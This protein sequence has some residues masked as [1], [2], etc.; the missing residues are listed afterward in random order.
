MSVA[1]PTRANVVS[2]FGRIT[3]VVREAAQKEDRRWEKIRLRPPNTNSTGA[4]VR[5]LDLDAEVF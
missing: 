4:L 2:L 3:C 5:C 1:G